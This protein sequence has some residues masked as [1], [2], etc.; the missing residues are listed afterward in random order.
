MTVNRSDAD[1]YD[2]L[3]LGFGQLFVFE[4]DNYNSHIPLSGGNEKN[5]VPLSRT[6]QAVSLL[7]VRTRY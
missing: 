2:R 5:S 6:L 1:R 3:L 7:I 4:R